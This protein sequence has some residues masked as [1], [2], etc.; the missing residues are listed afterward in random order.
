MI[1]KKK[2]EKGLRRNPKA[3]SGRNRK[4][5]RFLRPKTVIFSSH[6]PALKSRWGDASPRPLYD[7][8]TDCRFALSR[9]TSAS[10]YLLQKVDVSSKTSTSTFISFRQSARLFFASINF[11]E[12]SSLFMMGNQT[13]FIDPI[14]SVL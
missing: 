13:E 3:F 4:F 2:K 1:S 7:L 5:K 8:N 12:I 6:K 11:F 9:A 14:L 10:A